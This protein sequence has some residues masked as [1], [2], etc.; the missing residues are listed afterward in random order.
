[1]TWEMVPTIKPSSIL[2]FVLYNP[3]LV[4]QYC[5]IVDPT[6]ICRQFNGITEKAKQL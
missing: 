6:G 4:Q 2:K 3:H 1:M 5:N